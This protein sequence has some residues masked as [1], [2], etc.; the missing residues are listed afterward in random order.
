MYSEAFLSRTLSVPGKCV[1]FRGDDKFFSLITNACTY[2]L[3]INY[4]SCL[5]NKIK[6]VF[7]IEIT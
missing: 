5:K 3:S 2:F 6:Q 4:I 7:M 1:Q